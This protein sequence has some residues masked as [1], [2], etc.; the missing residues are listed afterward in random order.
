MVSRPEKSPGEPKVR[1]LMAV[2]MM[3]VMVVLVKKNTDV[4]L[5]G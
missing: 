3:M 1:M 4:G 2:N 5:D